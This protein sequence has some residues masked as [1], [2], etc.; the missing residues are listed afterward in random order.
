MT[1]HLPGLE[2]RNVTISIRVA[3]NGWIVS[4]R[5]YAHEQVVGDFE[6]TID[7]TA[8]EHVFTKKD[9]LRKY[10]IDAVKSAYPEVMRTAREEF[11]EKQNSAVRDQS[12]VDSD[13]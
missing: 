9:E 12:A 13:F 4:I 7:A 8:V 11:L 3:Q 2:N 6:S 10:L 5:H 1:L